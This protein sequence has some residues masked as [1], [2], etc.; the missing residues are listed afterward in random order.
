MVILMSIL[1][2][3]M[4]LD[5]SIKRNQFVSPVYRFEEWMYMRVVF[6]WLIAKNTKGRD[7]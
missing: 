7:A 6:G 4:Q 5:L 2:W 1:L 3:Q